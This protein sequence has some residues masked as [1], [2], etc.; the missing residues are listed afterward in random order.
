METGRVWES[1]TV[2]VLIL[3]GTKFLGRGVVDAAIAGGHEISIFT[4]GQTNPDLYPQIECLRGDL[5]LGELDALRNR[6]WDAVI[7]L[8]AVFVPNQVRRYAELLRDAVDHF[9][10]IGTIEV[11]ADHSKPYDEAAPLKAP[12]KPEP[13]SFDLEM[14]RLNRDLYGQLKVGTEYA[15]REIYG[16]RC[17]N[18]RAGWIVGPHDNSNRLLYWIRRLA[19]GGDVVAPGEPDRPIQLIDARDLGAFIVRL[20][21]QRA[22]GSYHGV[23]PDAPMTVDQMLRRIAGAVGSDPNLIWV[24]DQTLL[25]AQVRPSFDLPA[26]TPDAEK[27]CLMQASVKASVAAGLVVRPLEET[28]HDTIAWADAEGIELSSLMPEKEPRVLGMIAA[29]QG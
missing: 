1:N 9:N 25:D 14:A 24:D 6:R 16:D 7:D 4:R 26:W 28:V 22:T 10:L 27:C 21:E 12:A 29:R 23:G 20:S 3:G 13:Q 19:E 18:V 17:A 11:Y 2:K 8:G 15:I 5:E